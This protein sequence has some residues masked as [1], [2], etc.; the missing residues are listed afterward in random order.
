MYKIGQLY[1][2]GKRKLKEF[3][4]KSAEVSCTAR[5]PERHINYWREEWAARLES[6]IS[7]DEML[8]PSE[9]AYHVKWGEPVNKDLCE[10]IVTKEFK[11]KERDVPPGAL[12]DAIKQV[13]EGRS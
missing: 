12:A 3:I 6:I 4:G 2:D 8:R 10:G 11:W 9:D 5:F 1:A 13:K 7:S